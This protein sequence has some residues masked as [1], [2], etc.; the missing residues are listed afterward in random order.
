MSLKVLICSLLSDFI[1]LYIKDILLDN[2]KI[3]I[4]ISVL[5]AEVCAIGLVQRHQNIKTDR[6]V[7]V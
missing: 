4:N 2:V 7:S 3:E 6:K 1:V 5:L